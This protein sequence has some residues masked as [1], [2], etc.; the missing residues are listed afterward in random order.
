MRSL[1]EML[2][3]SS[4]LLVLRYAQHDGKSLVSDEDLHLQMALLKECRQ[5]VPLSDVAKYLRGRCGL[6]RRGV[7]LTFDAADARTVAS[8]A[9]LL[10]CHSLPAT[11]FMA[12]GEL[13]A[14]A[15]FGWAALQALRT[16]QLEFGS[17]TVSGR[18]LMG[19]P[20][21]EWRGELEASLRRMEQMLEV[22]C[23]SVAYPGQSDNSM[24][25]LLVESGLAGYR[26]ALSQQAGINRVGALEPFALRR[27]TVLPGTSRA[28][29]MSLLAHGGGGR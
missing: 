5:P 23:L 13:D 10:E 2:G 17:R 9:A 7:A 3:R 14:S 21:Q 19:R 26:L 25:N 24:P 8:T 20:T 4:N 29:F 22:P 16:E 18:P 27:V 15:N 1:A 28:A 12:S 6:P 11:F